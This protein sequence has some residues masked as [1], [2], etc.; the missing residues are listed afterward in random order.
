MSH[1]PIRHSIVT[2]NEELIST[3]YSTNNSIAIAIFDV[4]DQYGGPRQ[5]CWI[6]FRITV[7]LCCF[8]LSASTNRMTQQ[9]YP[10]FDIIIIF[11]ASIVSIYF[12]ISVAIHFYTIAV[13]YNGSLNAALS[14]IGNVLHGIVAR[15]GAAS[16]SRIR[17]HQGTCIVT[18]SLL[19]M[20]FTQAVA[21]G[22]FTT[23][24]KYNEPLDT[25]FFWP[26]AIYF[27]TIAAM[28]NEPLEAFLCHIVN[29]TNGMVIE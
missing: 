25:T 19:L 18:A 9:N 4:I 5:W 27:Y 1:G 17:L 21:N 3:Y 14:H 8:S 13:K 22:F 16:S 23:G 12:V 28:H 26:A 20:Q 24:M 29:V 7:P 11:L 6:Y 15:C 10:E 2:A